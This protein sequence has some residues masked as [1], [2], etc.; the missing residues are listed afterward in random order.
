MNYIA[1]LTGFYHK[2]LQDD[3]IS[4]THISLYM[5]LFQFWNDQRFR[6]SIIIQRSEIMD[7]SKIRSVA[8][9]HKGMKEL[10][11]YGYIIY[12]PS[13]NPFA[14]SRVT[15]TT[16]SIA[17]S[18]NAELLSE[19][20]AVSTSDSEQ[21][22]ERY[23]SEKSSNSELLNEPYTNINSNTN[24]KPCVYGHPQS[25][26]FEPGDNFDADAEKKEKLREKKKDEIEN[27]SQAKMI[28]PAPK[29]RKP[30]ISE[31]KMYFAEK[32]QPSEE[33]EKFFNHYES[34]GWLVGGKAEMKN[35]QAAARNWILN[36]KK[37]SAGFLAKNQSPEPRHLNASTGKSY[38]SKL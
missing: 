34:N 15:I 32:D 14:G 31:V 28:Y 20:V 26:K 2:I 27:S 37:F 6:K 9:Y 3:R 16:T 17:M 29:F 4:S 23:R 19:G 22:N 18:L 8:T 21:Q 13:Y 11:Q 24:N 10:H 33:A 1:H 12:E 30:Q 35:W 25:L 36:T 38:H 7:L 5:A